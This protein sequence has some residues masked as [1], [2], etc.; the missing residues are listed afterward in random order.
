MKR[1]ARF[2]PW[3]GLALATC[4]LHALAAPVSM[5]GGRT[6]GLHGFTNSGT[7]NFPPSR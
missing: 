7:A 3:H 6:N 2:R 5:V 4:L 1:V